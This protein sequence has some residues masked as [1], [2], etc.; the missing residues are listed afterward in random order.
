MNLIQIPLRQKQ[1]LPLQQEVKLQQ[2][3][4][5]G[6]FDALSS[7]QGNKGQF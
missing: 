2:S 7:E 6:V 5:E 3:L 1:R 4:L